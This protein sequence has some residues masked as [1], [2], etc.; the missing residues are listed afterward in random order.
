MNVASERLPRPR[1]ASLVVATAGVAAAM[2]AIAAILGGGAPMRARRARS[3]T[4]AAAYGY[5]SAC[6]TITRSREDPSYARVDFNRRRACGRFDWSVAAIFHRAHGSWQ[7]VLEAS[8]Y[9][10][11]VAG[12][13][14]AVQHDLSV[15]P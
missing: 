8:T 5:P 13:P 15:C 14:V 9:L 2:I 10:C 3:T 6:L 1:R 12:L 4:L 11:P 7:P